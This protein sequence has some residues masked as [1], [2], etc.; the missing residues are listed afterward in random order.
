MEF[1]AHAGKPQQTA[2]GYY[3]F[4]SPGEGVEAWVQA[5]LERQLSGCNPHYSGKGR[6]RVKINRVV[7]G[8]HSPLDGSVQGWLIDPETSAEICPIC[9]DLPAAA[10]DAPPISPPAIVWIQIAAFAR[11]SFCFSDYDA[12]KAS[13]FPY[14]NLASRAFIPSPS[15]PAG[16]NEDEAKPEAVFCGEIRHYELKTNPLTRLQF[17][18]FVVESLGGTFDV[19]ID[20]ESLNGTPRPDG[21]LA[22]AF[23][24]AGRIVG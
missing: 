20:R 2:H 1:A 6:V 12:M 17:H 24:L 15:S 14:A 4:W 19:V 8:P 16:S 7:A 13:T 22:G 18:Y 10:I 21:V 23:Y 9:V 5:S 3:I 11:Q